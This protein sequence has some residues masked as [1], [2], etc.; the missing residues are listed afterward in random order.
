VVVGQDDRALGEA[1]EPALYYGAFAQAQLDGLAQGLLIVRA[2]VER[3]VYPRRG[4][5]QLVAVVNE[6]IQRPFQ[7]TAHPLAIVNGHSPGVVNIDD[8]LPARPRGPHLKPIELYP[9]SQGHTLCLSVNLDFKLRNHYNFII[10]SRLV[11][12]NGANVRRIF[13]VLEGGERLDLWVLE[14]LGDPTLTRS[15]LQALIKAGAVKLNGQRA[16]AGLRLHPHDV[17]ELEL[18]DRAP[19]TVTPEPFTL[20]VLYED[21]HIIAIDKPSGMVVHPAAGH[22]HGTVV[23]Q[24]LS[25]CPLASFGAPK[26]PGIVHRLDEGTSGVLLVAKSDAAYLRLVEQFKRREIEKLYLALVWGRVLE[27]EGRIEGPIGRD[28][29]RRQQMK[30]LPTGKPAITEFR[31]LKR[32]PH[33]TLLVVR[34]VTGR[35]HQIRVHLSAI[36]HPVV[37][38]DLYARFRTSLDPHEPAAGEGERRSL[39][40][41]AWQLKLAHPITGERL[42]LSAPPPPEFETPRDQHIIEHRPVGE[43]H[44][45]VE[46]PAS[47]LSDQP[48]RGEHDDH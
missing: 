10:L 42:E 40:L 7:G 39:M 11:R 15:R 41:H 17:I 9:L 33:K 23:N 48:A 43:G 3:T 35:T 30:I 24:L 26:R 18:P 4:D 25:H 16:R 20:P 32:F 38:D 45:A 19:E 36:G 8:D 34:P 44:A 21:E 14:Q 13:R 46:Q 27:D 31:V 29:A 37:G 28:P 6:R 1:V 2:G 12:R 47:Y 22:A 5:L